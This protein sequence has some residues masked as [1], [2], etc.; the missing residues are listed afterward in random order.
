M[1]LD[2]QMIYSKKFKMWKKDKAVNSD[3][4]TLT[5]GK[6]STLVWQLCD[7]KKD[8]LDCQGRSPPGQNTRH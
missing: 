6:D 1:F 4:S 3:K 7:L 8:D 5:R 2:I